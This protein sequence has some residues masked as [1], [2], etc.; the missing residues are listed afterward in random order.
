MIPA[1]TTDQL[2][3]DRGQ[4]WPSSRQREW[5]RAADPSRA[6]TRVG[7]AVCL[8]DGGAAATHTSGVGWLILN[9]LGFGKWR[10]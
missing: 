10:W 3:L 6:V 2:S 1:N 9:Y 7:V 8:Y 4:P 5:R